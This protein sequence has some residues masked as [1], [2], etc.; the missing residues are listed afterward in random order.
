MSTRLCVVEVTGFEPATSSSRTKRATKLRHTSK[1]QPRINFGAY[2]CGTRIRTQTYRVRVC[3][4]T[5]TQFRIAL[6]LLY[7]NFK[8]CQ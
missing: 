3:C 2:G 8:I 1:K 7:T 6:I 5:L 4:A